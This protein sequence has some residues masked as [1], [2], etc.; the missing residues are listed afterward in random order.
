ME[1]AANTRQSANHV[2]TRSLADAVFLV[3]RQTVDGVASKTMQPKTASY[4]ICMECRSWSGFLSLSC[5]DGGFL[6][7]RPATTGHLNEPT[8]VCL[9]CQLSEITPVIFIPI[10]FIFLSLC[11]IS[12]HQ[13]LR[14]VPSHQF[15]VHFESWRRPLSS[16]SRSRR[17]LIEMHDSRRIGR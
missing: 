2:L 9:D 3:D 11:C 16:S 6:S 10:I 13:I 7:A 17:N 5:V 8:A 1:N 14:E 4:L 12:C 15:R